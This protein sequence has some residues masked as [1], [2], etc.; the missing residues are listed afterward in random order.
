MIGHANHPPVTH[1]YGQLVDIIRE[2]NL[3]MVTLDDVFLRR[4]APPS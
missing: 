1:V 4:G 3:S 2:R